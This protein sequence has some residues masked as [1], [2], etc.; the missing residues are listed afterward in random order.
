MVSQEIHLHAAI[1]ILVSVFFY[2]RTSTWKFHITFRTLAP[3]RI[4]L[5]EPIKEPCI[6]SPCGPYSQCLS[7]NGEAQCSCLPNYLGAPPSCRPECSTNSECALNLACINTKCIDPCPGSCAYN[8]LCT[9]QN[10][11]PSCHCP[12]DFIGDPFTSCQP[13]P[14]RKERSNKYWVPFL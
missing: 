4:V 8:A 1:Q 9:V 11:V 13:A 2:H 5:A 12:E 10:H 14:K 7:R 6:P 3:P